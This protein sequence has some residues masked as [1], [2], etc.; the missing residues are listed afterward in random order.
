MYSPHKHS[1]IQARSCGINPRVINRTVA[2]AR[3]NI[4]IDGIDFEPPYLRLSSHLPYTPIGNVDITR[5]PCAFDRWALPKLRRELHSKDE[6]LQ[7]CAI[8]TICDLCHDPE[9]AFDAI[10]LRI[11]NRLADLLLNSNEVIRERSL[12][13]LIVIANQAD[14]KTAITQNKVILQNLAELI[15]SEA[16]DLVRLKA[17]EVVYVVSE[18]WVTGCDLVENKFLTYLTDGIELETDEII[19]MRLKALYHLMTTTSSISEVM[20]LDGFGTCLDLLERDNVAVQAHALKCL[21]IL[22]SSPVGQELFLENKILYKLNKLLNHKNPDVYTYATSLLMF[23]TVH[24]K[25]KIKCKKFVNIPK[26]LLEL[27]NDRFTPYVQFFA[28]KA[29]T[30]ISEFPPIRMKVREKMDVVNN[31]IVDGDADLKRHKEILL[32]VLEKEPG[33][34]DEEDIMPGYYQQN[35]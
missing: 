27:C 5:R 15:A 30:N 33:V 7:I 12:Y 14:G 20:E 32:K 3:D 26:R 16:N 17:N 24:T 6:D 11:P 31:I 18:F 2:K 10:R 28:I 13:A 25:V 34:F 29:L 21:Q 23:G 22:T 4:V 8:T 1:Y 9:K 19:V 35:V